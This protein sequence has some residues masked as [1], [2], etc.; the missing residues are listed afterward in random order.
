MLMICIL[1]VADID[2]IGVP[3]A[4]QRRVTPRLAENRKAVQTS[5]PKVAAQRLPLGKGEGKSATRTGLR[6]VSR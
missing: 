5:Q 1:M 6:R 3:N 4:V 2:C